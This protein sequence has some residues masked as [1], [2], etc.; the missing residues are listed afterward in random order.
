MATVRTTTPRTDGGGKRKRKRVGKSKTASLSSP[1][2]IEAQLTTLEN[3]QR[4]LTVDMRELRRECFR[5]RRE[6]DKV[7]DVAEAAVEASERCA[8]QAS[9]AQQSATAACKAKD[10]ALEEA[11]K[12]VH[13]LET[14]ATTDM[15]KVMKKF[16][17][18]D[19]KLDRQKQDNEDT[20]MTQLT[21]FQEQYENELVKMKEDHAADLR[22]KQKQMASMERN[23]HKVMEENQRLVQKIT[24]MPTRQ[25]LNR[26]QEEIRTMERD[27]QE[28]QARTRA[29]LNT[30]EDRLVD[31]DRKMGDL[32]GPPEATMD[33]ERDGTQ[34][35]QQTVP[36]RRN[37]QS[38]R[39]TPEVIV[40][41]EDDDEE[42]DDEEEREE[43]S[44]AP[45]RAPPDVVLD[46]EDISQAD[47][48]I[49]EPPPDNTNAADRT[50]LTDLLE[51]ETDL[52]TGFLLYFCLGG[53]PDLD[54]QWTRYFSQLRTDEC[55]EMPRALRFQRRYIFLQNF[56]VYLTQC[57]LQAV[58]IN[59]Q[60]VSEEN[61]AFQAIGVL[62]VAAVRNRFYDV[63]EGIHLSWAKALVQQLSEDLASH[64]PL[65]SE[66]KLS[67]NPAGLSAAGD[68][69]ELI[70]EWRRLQAPALWTLA[71]ELHYGSLM[72]SVNSCEG[73]SPAVYL[74]ALMFDVLTVSSECPQSGSYRLNA[75]GGKMMSQLWNQ[76]LKKLPYVFFADWSW[77]DDQ[78]AKEKLPALGFCHLLA[79]ILLWNSAMDRYS[80]M[81]R[82]LY[83]D[84]VSQMLS[85][86][87][88]DRKPIRD[89]SDADA[90]SLLVSKCESTHI[91][92]LDIDA[93]FTA[94]LGLDGFFEV[95]E[96]IQSNML[97]VG[98]SA[99]PS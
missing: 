35:E 66:M 6:V 50:E 75:F 10:E 34:F 78:S 92:L 88:V 47:D 45:N 97:A 80:L 52:Q 38:R 22:A 62:D 15:A 5:V 68:N 33:N 25:E 61:E 2:S 81:N 4:S 39:R 12:K 8:L 60:T 24:Q 42:E 17:L 3:W 48:V 54:A 43:G 13:T 41:E 16:T 32:E 31:I 65:A 26:L 76:T 58:I 77:L 84:A 63:V 82:I 23:L 86:L 53:A 55:V 85:K 11:K 90:S 91:D 30:F 1:S 18:W 7:D 71:R 96:A 56:P 83:A 40:I 70:C 19:K 89:S 79:S 95:W 99:P 37:R 72:P 57:I 21:A 51:R 94:A 67:I 44:M 36:F 87:Y 98:M 20:L 28:E 29:D 93:K 14:R 69:D 59:R 74:F 49:M 73:V 64:E 46:E 27:N 9:A